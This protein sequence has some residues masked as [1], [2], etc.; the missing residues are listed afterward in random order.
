MERGKRGVTSSSSQSLGWTSVTLRMFL[1]TWRLRTSERHT[2]AMW[3]AFP[4]LSQQRLL[5]IMKQTSPSLCFVRPQQPQRPAISGLEF[6]RPCWLA[7]EDRS[8]W[9]WGVGWVRLTG[10][11]T[12][13]CSFMES[14]DRSWAVCCR[15][16]SLMWGRVSTFESKI[17]FLRSSS[18]QVERNLKIVMPSWSRDSMSASS[19]KESSF[20]R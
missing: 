8:G 5:A 17:F 6:G 12:L 18:P 14:M 4:H 15:T 19:F 11:I 20:S 2:V 1:P 3:P 7:R 10:A 13:V 9:F 16:S